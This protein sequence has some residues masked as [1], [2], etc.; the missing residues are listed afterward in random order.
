MI[1]LMAGAEVTENLR[2]VPI[3]TVLP[4][5][6]SQARPLTRLEPEEQS[7][8]WELAVEKAGDG[9]VTAAIVEEAVAEL[10]D[11]PSPIV[12]SKTPKDLRPQLL[13][14]AARSIR[15]AKKLSEGFEESEMNIL[16]KTI[17]RL[18]GRLEEADVEHEA[19]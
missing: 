16:L 13:R 9:R 6:E 5:T 2:T 10:S 8:V 12:H 11:D 15:E 4:T 14:D 1:R 3:G 18:I 7:V 17:R 19:A